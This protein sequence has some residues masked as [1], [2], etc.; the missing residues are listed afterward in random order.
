MEWGEVTEAAETGIVSIGSHTAS[1]PVLTNCSKAVMHTEML[2]SKITI[3]RNLGR[4]C[5]QFCYPFGTRNDFSQVTRQLVK[6]AGYTSALTTVVGLNNA[7]SD[8]FAL[9]RYMVDSRADWN[10]FL[11]RVNGFLGYAADVASRGFDW[12]RRHG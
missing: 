4:V 5:E 11:A 2:N 8:V 10:G 7:H 6:E 9:R 3:E 12:W 1:H